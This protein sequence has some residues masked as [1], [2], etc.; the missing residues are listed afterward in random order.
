M[1]DF[2]AI[3]TPLTTLLRKSSQWVWEGAAATAF[4][5]LKTAV[6]SAPV[7]QPFSASL[8]TYLTIDASGAAI[9][10]V[11]Q[12]GPNESCLRPVAYDS[13]KLNSAG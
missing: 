5:A 1:R 4:A 13:R 2:S 3:A 9:G 6:S 10:A 11:L 7:I 12:Q 8:P